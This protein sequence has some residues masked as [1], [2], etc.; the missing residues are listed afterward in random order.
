MTRRKQKNRPPLPILHKGAVLLGGNTNRITFSILADMLHPLLLSPGEY[1]ECL[2]MEE[3]IVLWPLR[4]E[5][6]YQEALDRNVKVAREA[7]A[8]A[9]PEAVA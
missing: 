4:P 1:V 5:G 3:C 2:V 8:A 9:P 7:V 6:L